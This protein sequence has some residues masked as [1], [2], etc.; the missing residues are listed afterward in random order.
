MPVSPAGES[1]D[2]V[3]GCTG[4]VSNQS[5]V[6]LHSKIYNE[7]SWFR[8]NTKPERKTTMRIKLIG[9]IAAFTLI[10]FATSAFAALTLEATK[11]MDLNG[12][13]EQWQVS[14]I[15]SASEQIN[16][17]SFLDLQAFGSGAGVHQAWQAITNAT[18]PTTDESKA[19]ALYGDDWIAYDTHFLFG[20]ADLALNLGSGWI[21]TNDMSTT[22]SLGL[23]QASANNA[24]TG[25]GS[26][27]L[28]PTGSRVILPGLA[29]PDVPFLQVVL[30]AGEQVALDIQ[31][32]A[33][34]GIEAII[35]GF[36]IGGGGGGD[37]PVVNDL[38]LSAMLNE[39]VMGTVGSMDADSFSGLLN[40][41]YT[42]GFG[43]TPPKPGAFFDPV[44]NPDTQE[45]SWNTKGSSRGIY[46]WEVTGTNSDGSDTGLISVEVPF[47]PEPATLSMLGLA[48]VGLV[49]IR[50][51]G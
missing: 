37:P 5:F 17:F 9:A 30:K 7:S 36:L 47:V 10:S 28:L 40:P 46:T 4:R 38:S 43:A 13:L 23:S 41:T 42:E 21:E 11:T 45:F 50:R 20:A 16:T 49:G 25:F 33:I 15:G 26:L 51:R 8:V 34:G 29:G 2:S 44:W 14:A 35:D 32:N 18:S 19:G 1:A 24:P 6:H 39:T 3:L 22:G 48:L 27:S 31:L 12:G